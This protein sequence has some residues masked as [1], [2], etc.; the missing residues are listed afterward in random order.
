MVC[1][2]ALFSCQQKYGDVL[3]TAVLHYMNILT[4]MNSHNCNYFIQLACFLSPQLAPLHKLLLGAKPLRMAEGCSVFA[5]SKL[6][7]SKQ[8]K[9]DC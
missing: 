1:S 3:N 9:D 4:L 2:F 6:T 8:K 5:I 7:E